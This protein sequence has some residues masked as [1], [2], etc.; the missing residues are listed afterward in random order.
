M[1][2]DD[3]AELRAIRSSLGDVPLVGLFCN[4]EISNA[5]LYT[6]A[7]VLSLIL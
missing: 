6:Y 4:G 7:G 3:S 1:F 5:R 2:G